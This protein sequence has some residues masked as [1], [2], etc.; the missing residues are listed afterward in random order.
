MLNSFQTLKPDSDA[1]TLHANGDKPSVL[2]L[3]FMEQEKWFD[4]PGYEGYYQI[5]SL[6]RIRGLYFFNYGK[7][8]KY[9]IPKIRKV[10]LSTTYP[11]I[12]LGFDI[13]GN[14]KTLYMHHIV[15]R[16]FIPNL[17]NFPVVMHKDD[18]KRNYNI[19]NLEW[20]THQ[21]NNNDAF[22]RGRLKKQMGS[23]NSRSKIDEKTAIE[24]FKH[25]GKGYELRHKFGVSYTAIYNIKNGYTW[26]HV[27][28]LP[29]KRKTKL[30]L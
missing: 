26:N 27:T 8:H 5:S 21:K 2:G 29:L 18:D 19:D 11:M 12:I 23:S 16:V 4:I 25:E 13:L 17:N 10:T 9:P 28:G 15:A 24:I 20:G 7:F 30:K 1:P 3:S 6:L 14:K 22:Y